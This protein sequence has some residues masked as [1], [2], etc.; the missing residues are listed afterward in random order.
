MTSTVPKLRGHVVLAELAQKEHTN[1]KKFSI[2]AVEGGIWASKHDDGEGIRLLLADM[3]YEP[4]DLNFIALQVSDFGNIASLAD[5]FA[6]FASSLRAQLN[7]LLTLP[8][9]DGNVLVLNLMPF[10]LSS[11]QIDKIIDGLYNE[12]ESL[13]RFRLVI[14]LIRNIDWLIKSGKFS[15]IRSTHDLK[16][17]VSAVDI[18]CFGV[19][20]ST[21]P[22]VHNFN[23][24]RAPFRKLLDISV[25]TIY[26]KLIFET[27]SYIGHYA[28]ANSHVR[29]HYDLTEFVKRDDVWEYLHE[30]FAEVIDA[31][32]HILLIGVGFETAAI[33][34]VG[35]LLSN[36]FQDRIID[37]R[38]GSIARIEEGD[39]DN[40]PQEFDL[41]VVLTDIVSTG[42]TLRSW[43]DILKTRGKGK[44]VR[45]FTI[46]KMRNSPDEIS[47]VEINTGVKIKRDFYS[48]NRSDCL[49]CQLNQ[50]IQHVR[51]AEDFRFVHPLQLTPY[52]FWEL[53]S[54]ARAFRRQA[55]TSMNSLRFRI[56]T[57]KIFDQYA[58]WFT[59]VIKSKFK[60]DWKDLKP[61]ALCTVDE[62][63]GIAFAQLVGKSI[64][65]EPIIR[66]N[67]NDL[68]QVTHH[69]GL[70]KG[71][72]NPLDGYNNI[73]AVDDG[74]NSG[75]TMEQIILFCLA[76][77]R[78]PMGAIVFDCRLTENDTKK[79]RNKM[80]F[81]PLVS[82]YQWPASSANL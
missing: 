27:N 48:K 50:P 33:S 53:V 7:S 1:L 47:N 30:K 19:H 25:E 31:A 41:A 38:P 11:T 46:A 78:I 70:P 43:I 51:N 24:T 65:V 16:H 60:S 71:I 34:T 80:L 76:A 55:P 42:K 74:I 66:V 39:L 57:S 26:H 72:G 63:T 45:A 67:R 4:S 8:Q 68:Q 81:N 69:G 49:L 13:N 14:F 56:D 59:N 20:F 79:I 18:R 22:Y 52:D 64:E 17:Q 54:S 44:P 5:Y 12:V 28:L 40:W 3:K 61:D 58:R 36:L 6:N 77:G 9:D 32:N 29:T 10:F 2:S 35:L 37:F 73:L 75:T 15:E 21:Y 62:P 82:L 23:V